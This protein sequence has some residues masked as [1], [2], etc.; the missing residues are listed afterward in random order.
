MLDVN[1]STDKE[2]KSKID[3]SMSAS[4]SLNNQ[5]KLRNFPFQW[6]SCINFVPKKDQTL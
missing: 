6:V 2:S 3:D 1:F 4:F 5:R